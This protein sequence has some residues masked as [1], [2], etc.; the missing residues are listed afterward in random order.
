MHQGRIY[1]VGAG[2]LAKKG[3][4]GRPY[5]EKWAP[6]D[7]QILGGKGNYFQLFP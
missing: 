6:L 5:N 4:L 1:R 7:A 2:L 3:I